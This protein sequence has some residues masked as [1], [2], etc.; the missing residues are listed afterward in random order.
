MAA[1]TAEQIKAAA[2]SKFL[3]PRLKK[4]PTFTRSGGKLPVSTIRSIA[5]G[6]LKAK[7]ATPAESASVR[8]KAFRMLPASIRANIKSSKK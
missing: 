4:F 3:I 2:P 7:D 5:S 8:Q 1:P 6:F